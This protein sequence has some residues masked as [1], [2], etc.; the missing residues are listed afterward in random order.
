MLFIF[1]VL[2]EMRLL[3]LYLLTLVTPPWC[4]SCLDSLLSSVYI[5]TKLFF[6]LFPFSLLFF[7]HFSKDMN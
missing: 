2:F 3:S 7:G 4:R 6:I 5:R 1:V